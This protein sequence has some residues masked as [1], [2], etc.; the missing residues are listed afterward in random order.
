MVELDVYLPK[1][2]LAF[3][4]QGEG[5]YHDVYSL[6]KRWVQ[7][8][9]DEEKRL[10]CRN[11]GITLVEVP[12]WWDFEESS[13]IATIRKERN[14]LFPLEEHGEPIPDQPS[15]SIPQGN[16]LTYLSIIEAMYGL[17]H[18]EVWDG[19]QDLKGW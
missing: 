9:L 4:Y 10:S 3:E 15:K 17:M 11:N 6:G 2:K 7:R 8:Q 5:H 16:Q 13:L 1:E 18:G 12:Y 19:R 14:E